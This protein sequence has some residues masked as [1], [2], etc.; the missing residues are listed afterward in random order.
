MGHKI[1]VFNT[2]WIQVV[3]N[4]GTLKLTQPE[5]IMGS[6]YWLSGS[7]YVKNIIKAILRIY[8]LNL[9]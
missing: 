8:L 5:S 3:H 1:R 2:T 4:L 9:I 6:K 7:L